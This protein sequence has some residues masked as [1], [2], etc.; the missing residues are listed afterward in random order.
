MEDFKIDSSVKPVGNIHNDAIATAVMLGRVKLQKNLE[1]VL[2]WVRSTPLN[3]GEVGK[4]RLTTCE[5]LIE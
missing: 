1:L 2:V 4:I 3:S 5:F